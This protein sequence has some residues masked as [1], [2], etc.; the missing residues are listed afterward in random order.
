MLVALLLS[1]GG[2]SVNAQTS[3][4]ASKEIYNWTPYG[5]VNMLNLFYDVLKQGRNYPTPQE[6][7]NTFGFD[8]EF[9]RSHV[10]PHAVMYNQAKQINPTINPKRKIW[11]NI[12]GGIGKGN[13]GYPSSLFNNDVYSLWQYTHL[14]GSWNHGIFQAPG[15][16]ADAAHKHG[17]DIFSGIKF[18]ESWTPGS[19]DATYAALISQKEGDKYKYAEPLINILM[20]MGLDGI[21]YNWED[22]SYSN[23][24][25]IAFHKE[26]YRIAKEKGLTFTSEV[27]LL[28]QGQPKVNLSVTSLDENDP[29]IHQEEQSMEND[30]SFLQYWPVISLGLAYNF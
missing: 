6:I 24:D 21:N 3:P 8:M 12:P 11:M 27:G 29:N 19:G 25:V 2:F 26:L 17:T 1:L 4:T 14:F 10:R 5:D 20:Y 18:F 16:W 23:A 9:S 30:L 15:S 28:Y 22:N 13:G 7:R